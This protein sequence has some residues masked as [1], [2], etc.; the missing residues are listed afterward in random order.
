[1]A[2]RGSLPAPTRQTQAASCDK[3]AEKRT[4]TD[5]VLRLRSGRVA[6][7]MTASP[8]RRTGVRPHW[9]QAAFSFAVADEPIFIPRSRFFASCIASFDPLSLLS[10]SSNVS[11]HPVLPARHI[12]GRPPAQATKT[13]H[14]MAPQASCTRLQKCSKVRSFTLNSSGVLPSGSHSVPRSLSFLASLVLNPSLLCL[15][16][17]GT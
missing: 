8:L 13:G 4:R 11:Q 9:I 7:I 14:A 15:T 6:R 10:S 5:E 12:I 17:L 2:W 16:F 1:M 3:P